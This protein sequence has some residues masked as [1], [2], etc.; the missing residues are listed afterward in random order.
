MIEVIQR[1][2]CKVKDMH[3]NRTPCIAVCVGRRW[4]FIFFHRLCMK[5]IKSQMRTQIT[6]VHLENC[7]RVATTSFEINFDALQYKVRRLTFK[8]FQLSKNMFDSQ[9]CF[10]F[11]NFFFC[12]IRLGKYLTTISPTGKRR[13]CVNCSTFAC[14]LVSIN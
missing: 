13:C 3:S 11:F 7:F 2:A 6:D 5:H 1:H 4:I 14:L 9:I 8:Y 10:I 12:Y